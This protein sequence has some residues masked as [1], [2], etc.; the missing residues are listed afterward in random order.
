MEPSELLQRSSR[1]LS[2]VDYRGCALGANSSRITHTSPG[3]ND[4][5][6]NSLMEPNV[7]HRETGSAD[8]AQCEIFITSTKY[9]PNC[10]FSNILCSVLLHRIVL[11]SVCMYRIVA[12]QP[13]GCNTIIKFSSKHRLQFTDYCMKSFFVECGN[14]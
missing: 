11:Y 2:P 10:I 3:G 8:D 13:F 7:I 12:I 1:S 14:C 9:R 4:D 6:R 5:A